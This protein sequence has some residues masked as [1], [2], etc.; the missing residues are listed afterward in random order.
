VKAKLT[1]VITKT[2]ATPVTE[3][4]VLWKREIEL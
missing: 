2:G 1:E 3:W 4:G